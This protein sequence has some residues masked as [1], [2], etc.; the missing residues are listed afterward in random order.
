MKRKGLALATKPVIPRCVYLSEAGAF[1]W[2]Q[3]PQE[4]AEAE[5]AV[6]GELVASLE[7]NGVE[8]VI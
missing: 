4:V 3:G 6:Y 7:E 2:E 1:Y 5:A 8:R